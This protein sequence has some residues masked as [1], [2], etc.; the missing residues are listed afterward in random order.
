VLI[1]RPMADGEL[2]IMLCEVKDVDLPAHRED[3]FESQARTVGKA[4]KQLDSKARWVAQNWATGFG[5]SL[6]PDLASRQHGTIVKM[7]TT[8]ERAPLEMMS[9]AECVPVPALKRFLWDV[10]LGLEPWF[11]ETRGASIIRF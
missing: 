5:I 2:L 6:F 11:Q 1:V 7:L 4:L 3:S 10:R 9:S 8:R